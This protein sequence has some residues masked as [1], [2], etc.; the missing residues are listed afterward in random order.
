M[1]NFPPLQRKELLSHPEENVSSSSFIWQ[2]WTMFGKSVSIQSSKS[3]SGCCSDLNR[4]FVVESPSFF[5]NS[6]VQNGD[7][8]FLFG[9][10]A[11][12]HTYVCTHILLHIHICVQPPTHQYTHTSLP[13]Y[14]T[15]RCIS[16]RKFLRQYIF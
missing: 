4:C 2:G 13:M 7:C 10:R 16:N 8:G 5:K 11:H 3:V 12:T 6:P 14:F 15:N 1:Q 9:V